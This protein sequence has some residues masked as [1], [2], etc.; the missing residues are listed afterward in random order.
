MPCRVYQSEEVAVE[1][2]EVPI[3]VMPVASSGYV[4]A[5]R[6]TAEFRPDGTKDQPAKLSA[7]VPTLLDAEMVLMLMSSKMR[8]QTLIRP[9]EVFWVTHSRSQEKQGL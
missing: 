9:E 5:R 4:M 8:H 3:S 1:V 2:A 7:V 6:V